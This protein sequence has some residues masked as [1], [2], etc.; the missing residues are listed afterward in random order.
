MSTVAPHSVRPS[1]AGFLSLRPAASP[2]SRIRPPTF[3]KLAG[4][5]GQ[6]ANFLERCHQQLALGEFDTASSLGWQVPPPRIAVSLAGRKDADWTLEE[7]ELA[8]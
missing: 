6:Q 1:H 7:D 5:A 8:F 2:A 4:G 3:A